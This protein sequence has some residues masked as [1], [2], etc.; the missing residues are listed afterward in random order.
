[1][2]SFHREDIA[3][4]LEISD[5]IRSKGVQP[6]DA[7]RC[8]KRRIGNKN[9]NVQLAALKVTLRLANAPVYPSD[10]ALTTLSS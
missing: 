9:P 8:L 1:L 4:N 10:V 3:L 6:R 7:M 5:I 2:F